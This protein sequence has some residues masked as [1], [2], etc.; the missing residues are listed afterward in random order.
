MTGV[1]T[2]ALPIYAKAAKA[3]KREAAKAAKN[4]GLTDEQ[5]ERKAALEKNKKTR[6]ENAAAYAQAIDKLKRTPAPTA[7]L[8][9]ILVESAIAGGFSAKRI[10]A[11]AD[12]LGIKLPKGLAS[13]GGGQGM[14]DVE[15]MRTMDVMD[16]TRVALAVILGKQLDDANKRAY[17]MPVDLEFVMNA[18]VPVT[19]G[20]PAAHVDTLLDE[21]PV[22]PKGKKKA[23]KKGGRK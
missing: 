9:A 6:A 7:L 14:R 11:A 4:G 12:L 10:A 23:P 22:K 16:L 19:A 18:A 21:V 15:L 8:V 3:A 2:C 13:E 1:Q 5:K 17:G 20:A